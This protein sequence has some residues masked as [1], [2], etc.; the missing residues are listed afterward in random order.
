MPEWVVEMAVHVN[1]DSEEEAI[2]KAKRKVWTWQGVASHA[3]EVDPEDME[4]E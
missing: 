4:D 3:E 2:R 1:A